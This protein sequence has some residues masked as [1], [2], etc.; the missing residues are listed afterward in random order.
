MLKILIVDDSL[1]IR[2]NL[3]KQLQDL[4]HEVIAT[5]KSG[6]EAIALYDRLKPDLVTMDITMPM[7]SGI[8][9]LKVIMSKDKDAK[10]IMVTSHGEENLVIDAIKSGAK[11][12]ILKPIT[13]GKI[14][15]AIDRVFPAW[16]TEEV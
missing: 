1:I 13:H 10:V 2:N 5:A 8:D 15:K 7:M 14:L 6:D 4:G 3:K 11:G 9:A 12:Y 16:E